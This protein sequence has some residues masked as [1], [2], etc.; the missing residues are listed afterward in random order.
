MMLRSAL[1][2]STVCFVALMLW[3]AISQ[4]QMSYVVVGDNRGSNGLVQAA[5]TEVC[6]QFSEGSVLRIEPGA[7]AELAE[8]TAAGARVVVRGGTLHARIEHLPD[9][10]W[11]FEA[12]P[13][14]VT[15]V[16]TEFSLTWT[17]TERKLAVELV[18]GSRVVSG[19]QAPGGVALGA[20][21]RLVAEEGT[22]TLRITALGN[23]RTDAPAVGTRT[24]AFAAPTELPAPPAVASGVGP[25]REEGSLG[26]TELVAAGR[27]ADVVDRAESAG[28]DEV[29]ATRALGDL[30]AL[31]DAARYV[32]RWDLAEKVLLAQRTRYPTSPQATTAAFLLGRLAEARGATADA[33]QWYQRYRQE[34]PS[35]ALAE[36]ALGRLMLLLA[37]S[38]SRGAA[39]T[40]AA[41]YLR[42]YP[43]GVS[44]RAA[45]ALLEEGE[46]P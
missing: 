16:G 14:T 28:V 35:G 11:F 4:R 29:L 15:V 40:A 18:T 38:Q 10:V 12:G 31:G 37:Q 33:L 13:Y 27:Y 7:S 42:R 39:R 2:A 9:A 30:L 44:A 1:V 20:G 43:A 24:Q 32:K 23:E 3:S 45:R 26:W 41:E 19:P 34:A 46:E 6:V 21:R 5:K 25:L 17:S 8:L 36:E 22:G